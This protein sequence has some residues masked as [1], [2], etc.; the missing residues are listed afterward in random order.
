MV[1]GLTINRF[2]D[3]IFLIRVLRKVWVVN[4]FPPAMIQ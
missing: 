4:W 3:V 2:P 1:E